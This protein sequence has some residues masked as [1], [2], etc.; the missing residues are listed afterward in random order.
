MQNP[1]EAARAR[2]AA[3]YNA[4]A[5][6]FDDAPLAFWDRY[7]RRT[8]E[9][10]NLKPGARVLDVGCGSGASAIPAAE[11]VGSNG[12]VIGVDVADRLLDK[13]RTK[14]RWRGLSHATFCYGDMTSLAFDDESFDAVVCVFS[15]FFV[16]D[17][18]RQARAL[19]RL[20][21]PG[22]TL[23]ITTWGRDFVEPGAS[24]WWQSISD[25]R[26]DL[27]RSF[28]PWDSIVEPETLL[29]MMNKAN[30]PGGLVVAEDGHQRLGCSEDW[31]TL[32]LGAGFRWT[33]EQLSADDVERVKEANIRA[34]RERAID[35][36]TTN[37]L[38]ATAIKPLCHAEKFRRSSAVTAGSG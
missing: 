16:P 35:K 5:D 7:G 8:V 10:I 1:Y 11:R 32:I 3:T 28:N 26:P 12:R 17:I 34:I 31:W 29:A 2:S 22:G 15:I 21:R 13:A 36:V 38:Y 4:A 6:H 23:A 30:I 14:A 24:I 27:A 33:V 19:W 25:V 20:V 37:V 18:A 9:R